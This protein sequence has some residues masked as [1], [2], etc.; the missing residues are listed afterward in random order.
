MLAREE[1]WIFEELISRFDS[2]SQALM[3]RRGSDGTQPWTFGVTGGRARTR[4]GRTSPANSDGCTVLGTYS[5]E[6]AI[7]CGGLQ[8]TEDASPAV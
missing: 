3:K 4:I 5:Q 2:L 6:G 1:L 8:C 7:D